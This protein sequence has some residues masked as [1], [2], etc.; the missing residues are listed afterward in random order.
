MADRDSNLANAFET[1]LTAELG[2]TGLSVAVPSTGNGPPSPCYLV[3]DPDNVAKR[4]YVYFDGAFT[5]TSFVTTSLTNRY[6][7]GSAA[8]SGITHSIGAKVRCVPTKQHFDDLHDRIDA[9]D[10]EALGMGFNVKSYGAVGDG[11]ADDR[12]AIQAAIA[13][14]IATG[15]GIVFFPK[16]T[17]RVTGT[18]TYSNHVVLAGAGTGATAIVGASLATAV[19]GP[20]APATRY[21]NV[22]ICDISVGNTSSGVA[23]GIGIDWAV[24]DGFVRQVAVN[25]VA[26]GL[27][28]A[29]ECYYNLIGPMRVTSVVDGFVLGTNTNEN[30][31]I[32]C[33]V[34]PTGTGFSINASSNTVFFN[35]SVE[36]GA[37]TYG[38]RISPSAATQ[39]IALYSPRVE[40]TGG[41]GIRVEATAQ[42]TYI[43]APHVLGGTPLSDLALDTILISDTYFGDQL[44]T[45]KLFLGTDATAEMLLKVASFGLHVRNPAD[46]GYLNVEGNDLVA[47]ERLWH[48]GTLVGFF[49]VTP[50]TR[51][52]ATAEIKAALAGLGLL[53]DGG[54][55]PL[56]L[57]GGALTTGDATLGGALDHDGATAGV[58]G[59]APVTRAAALVQNY[60]TADRTLA[61]YTAD[62]ESA[63][64]T[65]AADGEAKLA[66]LNALRVAYENLRAFTEDLAGFVNALVDDMQ[67][68]G[69]EQ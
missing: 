14:C 63:A 66:D 56:N 62:A 16:G 11:V 36:G 43:F 54:A 37:V 57:D 41:V 29:V 55:S 39:R 47:H 35:C 4:E 64:Y 15:G 25:N 51:P 44:R 49:N 67:A 50:V 22:G 46:N 31:F 2:P 10:P 27:R 24:T 9:V 53:T 65:G 7:A 32:R 58:F 6:L 18:V 28:T 13:A 45:N 33:R 52:G 60:S 30:S 19:I 48:R 20:A 69:W 21:F 38:W 61:A 34:S 26:T 12:A 59:V 17:Y 3:I 42:G 8:P 1:E 68:Y 40:I 23:G 5:G